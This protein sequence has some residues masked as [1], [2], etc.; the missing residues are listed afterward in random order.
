MPDYKF[1]D[2]DLDGLTY[3]LS[4]RK[5]VVKSYQ[6]LLS[7]LT[8]TLDDKT[9]ELIVLSLQITTHEPEAVKILIPKLLKIGATPD[10]I[11]DAVLLT[12]PNVGL[13]TV[14]KLL[15]K[16]LSEI[17]KYGEMTSGQD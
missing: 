1:N 15:P 10:E 17:R 16:V 3:L 8:V 5:D 12:I 2:Y 11:V 4:E 7:N 14:I 13:T 9:R 6:N